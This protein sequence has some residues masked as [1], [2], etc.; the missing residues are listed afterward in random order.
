MGLGVTNKLPLWAITPFTFLHKIQYWRWPIPSAWVCPTALLVTF[1]CSPIGRSRKAT[2][3][4]SLGSLFKNNKTN[5]QINET[6]FQDVI[7]SLTGGG[8]GFG[9]EVHVTQ[10]LVIIQPQRQRETFC[11]V[12]ENDSTWSSSTQIKSGETIGQ[13]EKGNATLQE[14]REEKKNRERQKLARNIKAASTT[15]GERDDATD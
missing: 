9:W 11:A 15:T 14:G 2:S 1:I 7:S 6:Y 4:L 8:G 13:M 12:A 5:K 3:K 10:Y